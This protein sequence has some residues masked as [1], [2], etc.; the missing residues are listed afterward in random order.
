MT[1]EAVAPPSGGSSVRLGR[2]GFVVEITDDEGVREASR[3]T[4]TT[5]CDG[6]GST[7]PASSKGVF[8]VDGA[9]VVVASDQ[10]TQKSTLTYL[11]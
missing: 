1:G 9:M 10:T 8:L 5:A 11:N 3:P 4:G 6:G 2:D 7:S